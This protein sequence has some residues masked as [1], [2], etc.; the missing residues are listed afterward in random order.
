MRVT[1]YDF[2]QVD[3]PC[4][5]GT[6]RS[7]IYERAGITTMT[8]PKAKLSAAAAAAAL[9]RRTVANCSCPPPATATATRQADVAFQGRHGGGRAL[10]PTVANVEA[11]R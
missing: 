7:R 4:W 6:K 1:E 11:Y 10:R 2:S 8:E 5:A 9:R 3:V